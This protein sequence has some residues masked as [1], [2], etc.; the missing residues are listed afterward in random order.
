MSG[1]C[2][3]L[4]SPAGNQP[5]VMQELPDVRVEAGYLRTETVYLRFETV[6]PRSEAVYSRSEA[7]YPRSEAVYLCSETVYVRGEIFVD[8]SDRIND[9]VVGARL[10]AAYGFAGAAAGGSVRFGA[11]H[12]SASG[13]LIEPSMPLRIVASGI[14]VHCSRKSDLRR[15][16]ASGRA[17]ASRCAQGSA[18]RD[19]LRAATEDNLSWLREQ[20]YRY[21][22]VSLERTRRFDESA[23]V[24]LTTAGAQQVQVQQVHSD[25]L[26]G[27]SERQSKAPR[28]QARYRR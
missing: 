5:E 24:S 6:Y 10:G 12:A 14:A 3:V 20:G 15:R 22:V 18:D 27:H 25:D 13:T 19:G 9:M 28:F 11:T 8:G 17:G 1:Q 21:L 2:Q 4:R 23:A 16:G 26:D 7:V